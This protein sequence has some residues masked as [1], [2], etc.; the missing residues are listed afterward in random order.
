MNSTLKNSDYTDLNDDGRPIIPKQED[1][2]GQGCNPCI[3]DIYQKLL[4]EWKDKKLNTKQIDL[5]SKN[6]LS[7]IKYNKFIVNAIEKASEDC[8]F[9][10]TKTV[11]LY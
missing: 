6:Y 3:F 1:C 2:C 5:F 8:I 9:I 4:Q 10:E 7:P 11:G